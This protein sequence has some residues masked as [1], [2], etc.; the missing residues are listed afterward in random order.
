MDNATNNSQRLTRT[1][2]LRAMQTLIITMGGVK[3]YGVWLDA[4]PEGATLSPSGGVEQSALMAIASN[5]ESYNAAVKA[6]AQVM[7]PV[8]SAM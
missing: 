4:M 2:N 1:Q 6:F 3:G 5:D 8:L 7:A